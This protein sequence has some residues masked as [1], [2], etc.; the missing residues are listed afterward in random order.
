MGLKYPKN[1][2]LNFE[3]ELS[4]EVLHI[5]CF[6]WLFQ[7]SADRFTVDLQIDASATCHVDMYMWQS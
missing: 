7:K 1:I 2:S 4:A 5:V 6:G 3:K